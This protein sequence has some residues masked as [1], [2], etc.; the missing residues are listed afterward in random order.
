M[1]SSSESTVPAPSFDGDPLLQPPAPHDEHVHDNLQNPSDALL[2]LAH[3]AEDNDPG[4]NPS[5]GATSGSDVIQPTNFPEE[6]RPSR[7]EAPE[8]LSV[9]REQPNSVSAYQPVK[10]GSVEPKVIEHLLRQ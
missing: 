8:S 6:M 2:I 9:S 1:Q 10:E 3:A 7:T 5:F 4:A